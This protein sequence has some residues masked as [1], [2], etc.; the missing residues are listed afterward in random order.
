M[1]TQAEFREMAQFIAQN[2]DTIPRSSQPVSEYAKSVALRA[3]YE[4]FDHM[5]NKETEKK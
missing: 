4:A 2:F 3:V 1:T 5:G